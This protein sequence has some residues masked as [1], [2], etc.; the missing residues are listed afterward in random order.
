MPVSFESLVVGKTYD[1]P[2]LARLWGYH[3]FQAISRGVVTPAATKLIILFVT[4]EKQESLTQYKDYLD[5]PFLHWEGEAKHSSDRRVIN[6][7]IEGQE[8]HLFHRKVHHTPFTYLG[9]IRLEQHSLQSDAPSQF[10]FTLESRHDLECQYEVGEVLEPY[11]VVPAPEL[12]HLLPTEREAIVRS[13]V[14]QGVFRDGLLRLWGG[15]AVTGYQKRPVLLLASH[16]KPWKIASNRERLDPHNGLL[17]QPTVDRLFDKGLVS[18]D[19]KG[20]LLL[21]DGFTSDELQQLGVD[22]RSQ[23]RKL[24]DQTMVYLEHHRR[25]E[26]G[27]LSP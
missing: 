14:G 3:G 7:A 2:F 22:P 17:L 5:G 1:R 24:P 15:C 20:K 9:Q 19:R 4:E 26:F 16:I 21:A 27:R 25:H 18:F 23:L 10:I 6:A 8:I 11:E 13:R 12:A